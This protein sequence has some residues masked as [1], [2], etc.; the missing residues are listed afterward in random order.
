MIAAL[1]TLRLPVARLRARPYT[2]LFVLLMFGVAPIFALRKAS[3]WMIVFVPTASLLWRGQDIYDQ[4]LGYV[5]PPLQ[6]V[7]AVPVL[8]LPPVLQRLAWLAVNAAALWGTLR[9]AWRLAGG[10]DLETEPARRREH[11]AFVLGLIIGLTY[12]LNSLMHQQTD[13]LLAWL[14]FRGGEAL[15]EQHHRGAAVRFGLAAAMK[16][17]PLLFAPYLLLRGKRVAA[18]VV[19]GVFVGA[20]LLP[21]LVHAPKTHSTW[22][23]KWVSLFLAPMTRA[24]H[25]PGEWASAIVYNQSL[26]G[27]F[28]RWSGTT[29]TAT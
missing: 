10:E 2:G 27:A 18:V 19:F 13:I 11:V 14:I 9:S 17:T 22:L 26:L 24:D 15:G 8:P 29:V 5:Y 21:D 20:S 4:P 16:C 3:D 12:F 1:P 28:N 23:Q 7:L 25:R 6:A